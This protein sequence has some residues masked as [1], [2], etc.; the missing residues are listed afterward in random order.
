[1]GQDTFALFGLVEPAATQAVTANT[2]AG[3]YFMGDELPNDPS[4]PNR[5]G[6]VAINSGG[7]ALAQKTTAP[8][9][10]FF[11]N[12]MG[13]SASITVLEKQ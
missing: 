13:G 1:M 2:L 11:Q 8:K 3:N 5:I 6:V 7:A 9:L 10:L 4:A 12:G